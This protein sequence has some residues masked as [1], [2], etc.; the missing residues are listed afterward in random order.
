MRVDVDVDVANRIDLSLKQR[1]H[2]VSPG[3]STA[4]QVLDQEKKHVPV[5]MLFCL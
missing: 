3:T 5:V 2:P 4:E 1:G